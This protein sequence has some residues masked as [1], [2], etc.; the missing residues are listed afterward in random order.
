MALGDKKVAQAA[1]QSRLEAEVEHLRDENAFLRRNVEKLQEAL[2]AK[3]SPLAYEQMKMD[4]AA[5]G[6]PYDGF[7]EEE[8]ERR[9]REAEIT[10]QYLASLEEPMFRSAEDMV[11]KLT[12]VMG[13]PVP[14]S[15]HENEES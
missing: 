15:I 3:E 14:T 6:T 7:S 13:A 10:K 4:E 5:L 2:Y 9:K 1:A 11:S 12:K 8:I